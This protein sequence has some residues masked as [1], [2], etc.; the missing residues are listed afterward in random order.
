MC[1]NYRLLENDINTSENSLAVLKLTMHLRPSNSTLRYR[2]TEMHTSVRQKT[3]TPI[4]VNITTKYNNQ[5][6]D[7]AQM[8]VNT[9]MDI[10]IGE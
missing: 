10:S 8:P 1:S 5:K 4:K 2:S 9:R 6:K 3:N 7:I